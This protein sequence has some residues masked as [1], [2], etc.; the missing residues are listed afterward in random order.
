MHGDSEFA[1]AA[2]D[3]L[4]SG[5]EREFEDCVYDLLGV[6]QWGRCDDL[7]SRI[8]CQVVKEGRVVRHWQNGADVDNLVQFIG[9]EF[10]AQD[11]AESGDAVLG[12][13]VRVYSMA[14]VPWQDP[15]PD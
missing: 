5:F 15:T 11:L 9:F 2:D 1:C 13:D 10:L 4:I 14:M 8:V 7:V 3:D 12:G 6:I